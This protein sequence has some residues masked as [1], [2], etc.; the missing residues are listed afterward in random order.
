MESIKLK[1]LP[2]FVC[3][4]EAGGPEGGKVPSL[5]ST[6]RVLRKQTD[7]GTGDIRK[8]RHPRAFTWMYTKLGVWF[9]PQRRQFSSQARHLSEDL[10]LWGTWDNPTLEKKEVCLAIFFAASLSCSVALVIFFFVCHYLNCWNR[11]ALW[12]LALCLWL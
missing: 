10:D 11:F 2:A 1:E 6:C 3:S 8:E 12:S 7:F 4:A 9:N 5:F